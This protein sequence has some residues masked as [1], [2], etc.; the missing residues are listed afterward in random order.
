M[1]IMEKKKQRL[2]VLR[3][4]VHWR[5]LPMPQTV[6]CV[7]KK[8]PLEVCAGNKR[9]IF[10]KTR[11]ASRETG[12]G[13]LASS[14]NPARFSKTRLR[15]KSLS[16]VALSHES[17]ITRQVFYMYTF[18]T[19]YIGYVWC[20]IGFVVGA[21]DH[22]C[23]PSHERSEWVGDLARL[24]YAASA[25]QTK[26]THQINRGW[27]AVLLSRARPAFR[28]FAS[29]ADQARLKIKTAIHRLWPHRQLQYCNFSAYKKTHYCLL[30]YSR[31]VYANKYIL[32]LDWK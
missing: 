3:I 23:V 30:F 1:L 13:P 4:W 12:L 22:S 7:L 25:N 28:P 19:K 2:W 16:S 31:W 17:E 20:I 32:V 18:P 5:T 9:L 8:H 27:H 11:T 21:A 10:L 24:Q 6:A 26:Y 14:R 15:W 29:P